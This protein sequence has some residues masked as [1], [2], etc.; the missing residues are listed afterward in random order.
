LEIIYMDANNH[1]DESWAKTKAIEIKN[2][3]AIEKPDLIIAAD[4]TAT[5]FVIMPYFKDAAIPVVFC[6]INWDATVYGMPYKN[7]TGMLEVSAIPELIARMQDYTKGNR[8]GYIAGDTLTQRKEA[9]TIEKKF[10]LKFTTTEFVGSMS[11]WKTAFMKVQANSDM[12]F[13]YNNAGIQDWNATEASVF[14]LANAKTPI[15]TTVE[16]MMPYAHIGYTKVPE[17]QGRWAAETAMKIF[18][19]IAPNA[20]PIV[21]NQQGKVI[22]NVKLA[23][24]LGIIFKTSLI[25]NAIILNDK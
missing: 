19:G 22:L 16:W 25:K 21:E 18:D 14:I 4:D 24:E 13:F 8:I 20:I 2:K 6:G 1:P 15:G 3:I 10:S 23:N 17:E 7:T 11:D 5:K 9:A 12:I